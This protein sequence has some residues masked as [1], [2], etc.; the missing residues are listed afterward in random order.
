MSYGV[1]K[2][3]IPSTKFQVPSKGKMSKV[4]DKKSY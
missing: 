1:K 2:H 4:D 3:Q